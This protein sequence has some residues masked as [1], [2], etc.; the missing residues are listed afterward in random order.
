[1]TKEGKEPI[2]S[3]DSSLKRRILLALVGGIAVVLTGDPEGLDFT[4]KS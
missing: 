4:K 1:M 3:I 2:G